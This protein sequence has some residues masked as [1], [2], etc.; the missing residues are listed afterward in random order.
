MRLS[1]RLVT[2]LTM[3]FVGCCNDHRPDARQCA[4]QHLLAPKN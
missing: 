3:L 2:S 1:I 4:S